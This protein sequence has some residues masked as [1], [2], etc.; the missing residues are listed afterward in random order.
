VTA[1]KG[2]SGVCQHRVTSFMDD[3]VEND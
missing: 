1:R 3:P 2:L